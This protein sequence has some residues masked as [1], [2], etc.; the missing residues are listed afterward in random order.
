MKQK[1]ILGIIGV[2]VIG[3][4]IVI[5]Y[6]FSQKTYLIDQHAAAIL[7]CYTGD[8]S[9][10]TDQ[11]I[12]NNSVQYV[13]ETS[14][15]FINMP[16]DLYP[17]DLQYS[18]TTV[19]GNASAGSVGG[20]FGEAEGAAPGCWSSYMDFEG[21]GEVDLRVKS[22]VEGAPDYFVRFIVSSV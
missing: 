22:V 13:K 7:A 4:L 20:G 8:S 19:A 21:S 1:T 5:V 6:F 14:R 10:T 11:P 18:W 12:P 16:K 17:R 2:V 3:A 15:L 9:G